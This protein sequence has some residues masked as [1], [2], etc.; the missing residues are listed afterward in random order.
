MNGLKLKNLREGQ[1]VWVPIYENNTMHVVDKTNMY[2]I[3]ELV[4]CLIFKIN[5]EPMDE[6]NST[7][8]LGLPK[9]YGTRVSSKYLR[10]CEVTASDYLTYQFDVCTWF[11]L[12]GIHSTFD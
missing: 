10:N 7:I 2:S 9:G 12:S 3:K 1:L 5:P 6:D 11:K 4:L 8:I